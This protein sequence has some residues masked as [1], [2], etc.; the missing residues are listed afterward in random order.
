MMYKE[1][2]VIMGLWGFYAIK[3]SITLYKKSLAMPEMQA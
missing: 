2:P 1:S 3:K